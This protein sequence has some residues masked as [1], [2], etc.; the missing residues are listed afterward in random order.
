MSINKLVAQYCN[1]S[2]SDI[3]FEVWNDTHNHVIAKQVR[4]I[5][6]NLEWTTHIK[7]EFDSIFTDEVNEMFSWK[8]K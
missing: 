4:D 2:T 8:N 1:K 7:N 6:Y 3:Y 5:V